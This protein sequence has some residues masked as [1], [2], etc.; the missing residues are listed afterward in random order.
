MKFDKFPTRRIFVRKEMDGK[1]VER[2]IRGNQ[3]R[4]INYSIIIINIHFGLSKHDYPKDK[5]VIFSTSLFI[6]NLNLQMKKMQ[7]DQHSD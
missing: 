4:N 6:S 3:E 2:R 5:W 1:A 7:L